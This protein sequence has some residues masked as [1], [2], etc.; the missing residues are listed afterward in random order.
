MSIG[1]DN[2]IK[3]ASSQSG[4]VFQKW[5]DCHEDTI[6]TVAWIN[7]FV[8][9]T[10]DDSGII[11][12]WDTRQSKA[13][14]EFTTHEDYISSLLAIDQKFV[15]S[16]SGDGT[17]AIHDLRASTATSSSSSSSKKSKSLVKKSDDQE[18]ELTSCVFLKSTS[19]KPR[20]CAGTSSGVIA[21][22]NKNDK[23]LLSNDRILPPAIDLK[24]R[25]H[26]DTKKS[27]GSIDDGEIGIE[28]MVKVDEDKVVV[29]GGDGKV[30]LLEVLPNQY[31]RLVG[32]F[33]TSEPVQDVVVHNDLVFAVSS[34]YVR[35]WPIE[36]GEE[37]HEVNIDARVQSDDSIRE[38]APHEIE[39]DSS[40]TEATRPET[41]DIDPDSKQAPSDVEPEEPKR[42]KPKKAK[43]LRE[44]KRNTFFDDM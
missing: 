30:R 27:V 38:E 8:F 42:K 5:V 13:S 22:F 43:P 4:K 14:K 34:N 36:A 19:S 10:G 15:V 41:Q 18:D 1:A 33:G 26:G 6:N 39:S 17:L 40:E 28:C 35:V 44:V 20:I 11:K 9:C 31:L 12:A 25:S 16:T 2:I 24:D 29:G 23:Y 21:I 37:E 32:D 7:S 3:L